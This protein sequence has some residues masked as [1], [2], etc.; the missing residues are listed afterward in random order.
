MSKALAKFWPSSCE[1]PIWRALP[2]RMRDSTAKV[3]RA[4]AKRSASVLMPRSTGSASTFSMKS[5]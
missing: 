2:S 1:V 4:P 5:A 3:F